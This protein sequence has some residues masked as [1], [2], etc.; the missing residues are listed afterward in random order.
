MECE[1]LN[2]FSRAKLDFMTALKQRKKNDT[3]FCCL[4]RVHAYLHFIHCNATEMMTK[5]IN[6]EV[7]F[8]LFEK[9]FL[10][11]LKECALHKKPA[12]AMYEFEK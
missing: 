2:I 8:H 12:I 9:H 4:F 10:R 5:Q 1:Y 11:M 7:N 6:K 3:I